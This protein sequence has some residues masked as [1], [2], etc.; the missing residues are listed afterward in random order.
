MMR[1]G[2]IRERKTPPDTRVALTPKQCANLMQQYPGMT[3]VVEPSPNRCYTDDEYRAEG[4]TIQEDLSDCDV[5][6]GIKEVKIDYLIPGKTYFFFSHTKKK[7]PYNQKLMQALIEK[8]IRMI[9]YECLT[10][11]D[12]QRILG[13]GLYAGIVGAHNGLLTYG[14]KTGTYQLPAAHEVGSYE[15]ML[16]AYEQA[17]IPNIK[18]VVTGS[19]K[20]AA[21]IL[22]VMTQLDIESVEPE[23]FL[24]HQ[25]DYPVYTH[26]KGAALY[27]RKDN[28]LFHRDD[29]HANPEAYKCL[30]SQYVSQTD[31]LMNGIYWDEKIAR[32]FE[33]QD[34]LRNDWRISVISDITCDVDG[35][36]PINVG[37]STIA[38]PVYGI[39]R[40]TQEKE[41]AFQPNKEVID[42]M[43]VDNLPNELPRD[44]SQYFGVHF[45]KFVLS[46]LLKEESDI[47]RRATICED[48]KL[49]SHYEYLSDYAYA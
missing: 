45:E 6:L 22:D 8:K 28:D 24:T 7:Q 10:H 11:I 3:I 17:I 20:V 33:K 29:F 9:D 37:A 39:N 2:L 38:D 25:Y 19:G 14:K 12:E 32:L 41:V 31:I 27:A 44:A 4:I 43:A 46:E 15:D 5:L 26:L 40:K 30:F 42:V 49:T 13:F 48:G 18:I 47:I 1:I 21:G 35:S 36:V 23:D 16:K 34:I